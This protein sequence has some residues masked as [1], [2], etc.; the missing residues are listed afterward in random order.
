MR[1]PARGRLLL[2]A[3]AAMV[4]L[5]AVGSVRVARG[6]NG[7]ALT[8]TRT[9]SAVGG[10]TVLDPVRATDLPVGD[11]APPV[12]ADRW[13]NTTPLT[14]RELAGSVVLYDF[15]T[16]GCINCLHTQPYVKAWYRRY[17]ADGLIVLSIHS[18]EFGYE[19]DPVAVADYVRKA[20]ITYP[21]AL[22]PSFSTW[23]SFHNRYWPAFYLHDRQG[24]RRLER[25][26][27]GG[28]R[29]TEDAIRALLGVDPHSPLATTG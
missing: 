12:R 27:E 29:Q 1:G 23:H 9:G 14:P 4:V 19:A 2:V 24:H 15:W 5:A 20:G 18:P 6:L 13:L 7:D 8:S 17:A 25:V 11:P 16:F 21:V 28:Y 3:V 26:G 10:G 22:D